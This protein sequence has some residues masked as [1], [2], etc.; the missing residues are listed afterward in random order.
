MKKIINLFLPAFLIIVG[1]QFTR[2]YLGDTQNEKKETLQELINNGEQTSATLSN[3]YTEKTTKIAKIPIKT[4][5]VEYTFLV[6]ETKYSGVKK[7]KSPPETT[8]MTVT[9]LAMNPEKNAINPLAELAEINEYEN[10]SSTLIVGLVLMFA[11]LTLGF[12][13]IKALKKHF[14]Q[15]AA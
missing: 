8:N 2:D 9:Y 15:Q 3:E 4:Y 13:R 10:S 5:E 11:G 1:I 12:F 7:L 14:S 6:N